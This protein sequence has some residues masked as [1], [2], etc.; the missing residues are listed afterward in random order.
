MFDTAVIKVAQRAINCKMCVLEQVYTYSIFLNVLVNGG[1]M[2]QALQLFEE[3]C[4]AAARLC[5]LLPSTANSW[6]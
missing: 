2:D 3:V 5:V 4:I 1:D 6:L